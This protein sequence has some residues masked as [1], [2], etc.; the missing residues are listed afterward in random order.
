M[1][2][3]IEYE[4]RLNNLTEIYSYLPDEKDRDTILGIFNKRYDENYISDYLAFILD[5]YRNGIGTQ[6]L[7]MILDY[8]TEEDNSLS[9]EDN[10]E[11]NREFTLSNNRRIDL[12]ITQLSALGFSDKTLINIG[13][14]SKK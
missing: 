9:K 7:N 11:I 8:F 13:R 4:R 5:P 14:S 3:M 2:R 1:S 10:I 6:P 12:L